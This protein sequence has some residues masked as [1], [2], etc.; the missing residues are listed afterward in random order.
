MASLTN[1]E[2]IAAVDRKARQDPIFRG[3]LEN[4][5]QNK[6]ERSIRRLIAVIIGEATKAAVMAII[7][8][9]SQRL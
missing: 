3:N 6:D 1:D 9:F 4:A 2:L 8:W 7:N 5:V